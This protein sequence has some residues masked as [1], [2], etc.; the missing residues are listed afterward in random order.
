MPVPFSHQNQNILKTDAKGDRHF[1]STFF[2]VLSTTFTLQMQAVSCNI[3]AHQI[4]HRLRS[5][6]SRCL[7]VFKKKN[8]SGDQDNSVRESQYGWK[9]RRMEAVAFDCSANVSH[10]AHCRP[11]KPLSRFG[12]GIFVNFSYHESKKYDTI[13]E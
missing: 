11:G 12:S 9:R 7:T 8:T 6:H 13:K 4:R 5:N 1:L 3:K 2:L 10:R